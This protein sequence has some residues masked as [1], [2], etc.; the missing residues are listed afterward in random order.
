[1][2]IGTETVDAPLKTNTETLDTFRGIF[3]R[4][5]GRALDTC[6]VKVLKSTSLFGSNP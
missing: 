5:I 3:D 4:A 2:K 6:G 1:M